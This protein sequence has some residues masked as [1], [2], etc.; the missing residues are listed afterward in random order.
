M[1]SNLF[2]IKFDSILSTHY[3]HIGNDKITAKQ[4]IEDPRAR[5]VSIFEPFAVELT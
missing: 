1:L 2:V 4:Y 5:V 3:F